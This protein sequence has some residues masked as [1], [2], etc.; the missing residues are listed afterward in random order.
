[1]KDLPLFPDAASA[2]APG[3]DGLYFALVAF[4]VFFTVLIFALIFFFAVKYKRTSPDQVGVPLHGSTVLEIIWSV[5]PFL[6]I[7]AVFVWATKLYF[8]VYTPQPDAMEVFVIGKQWMWKMQHPEGVREINTLHLPAGRMVK[9]TMISEDVIHSFYVP[10]F[11]VKRDVLPGRYSS[12]YFKPTTPGK[13]HLFCAEYCG[14]QHSGMGGWIYVM[15]P[16]E[17]ENW[18]SGGPGGSM[19]TRGEQLFQQYGCA[20]CHR[21]DGKGR[22]PSLVGIFN[23]PQ[24]LQG[25]TTVIADE[26][27][28][29]ESILTPKAKVV[30]GFQAVM[31]TFQGQISEESLLQLI[32]YIKSLEKPESEDIQ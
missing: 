30:Q 11:R 10:A 24:K 29:R 28:I 17:Y 18:L 22:G 1:M 2:I 3:I 23:Q 15:E 8:K 13:Y 9:L 32:A 6:V 31:P 25:G 16:G 26:V 27:Y 20:S 5:G 12:M 19:Q 14:T 21:S 4:S 7:C